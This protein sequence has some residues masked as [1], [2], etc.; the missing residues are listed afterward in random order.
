MIG[1]ETSP[2]RARLASF[3]NAYAVATRMCEAT[4]TDQFVYPTGD[5]IQPYRITA[6]CLACEG[7]PLARIA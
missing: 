1:I 6:D 5:P 4:G 7:R 3:E 2:K